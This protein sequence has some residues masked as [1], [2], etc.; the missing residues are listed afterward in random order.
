MFEDAVGHNQEYSDEPLLIIN[1]D[2]WIQS[3]TEKQAVMLEI[4]RTRQADVN[5][6]SIAV[7]N[8]NRDN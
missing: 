2:E 5:E 8:E 3:L 7:R 1:T 4:A 6:D